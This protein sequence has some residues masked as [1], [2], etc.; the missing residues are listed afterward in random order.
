MG[1][2]A[3]GDVIEAFPVFDLVRELWPETHLAVGCQTKAQE[4]ALEIYPQ[5]L[6][7]IAIRRGSVRLWKPA[8][9]AL[10][11]NLEAMRGFDAI[12]FLYKNRVCWPMRVTAWLTGARVWHGHDYRYRNGQRNPYSDFP[13][14]VFNQ[15][16]A[17]DLLGLPLSRLREGRVA[18]PEADQEFARDFLS[19]HG[20]GRRPIVILNSLASPVMPGWG[21]ERYGHVANALVERGV[22]VII[23]AGTKAQLEQYRR[24]ADRLRREVI[25][26]ETRTPAMLAAVMARCD[27]V[28]GEPSGQ[29]WLATSVGVPIVALLGPGERN[30]HGQGR[31]GPPW[32]P[33][34]QRHRF[35]SK[36]DWCQTSMGTRCRCKYGEKPYGGWIKAMKLVAIWKPWK[37][38]LERLGLVGHPGEI[39]VGGTPCLEAIQVAEVVDAAWSQLGLAQPA[40]AG[41]ER[42]RTSVAG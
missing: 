17:A 24:V 29:S 31:S 6:E 34:D 23:N 20:L 28:V 19:R 8:I 25:L 36:M 16:V 26:L 13:G 2:R 21:M 15:I 37:R 30:Y 32:W 4:S 11:E 42:E 12:L 9:R 35:I 3:F 10:R 38:R 7:R 1:S 40:A 5:A 22:D 39:K 27:L 41:K 14:R 33:R 18:V